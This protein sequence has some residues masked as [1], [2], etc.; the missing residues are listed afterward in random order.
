MTSS[1]GDLIHLCLLALLLLVPTTNGQAAVTTDCI[2]ITLPARVINRSL[3]AVLPLPITSHNKH[4]EGKLVIES[5]NKL[6]M[7][8]NA[9]SLQG[10]IT[11]NNLAISARIGDR[12]IRLKIGRM[13]MPMTCDLT[14]RFDPVKK[15]LFVTP[16]FAKPQ[17]R[18]GDPANAMLPLLAIL[19]NREYPVTLTSLQSFKAKV[20]SRSVSF[21]MEPKEIKVSRNQVKI[22]LIPRL[23]KKN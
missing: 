18:P 17:I 3:H 10:L 8:D 20:G 7:H 11:G 2:T 23:V 14:L 21:D 22:T 5:I 15:I 19:D 1:A 6:E 4:V 13:Q 9:I 16:H 12:D